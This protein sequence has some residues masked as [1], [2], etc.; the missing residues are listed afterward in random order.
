MIESITILGIQVKNDLVFAFQRLT[1]QERNIYRNKQH[2]VLQGFKVQNYIGVN[3]ME[4][5]IAKLNSITEIKH[6]VC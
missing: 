6:I 4:H 3:T 5:R 2:D 1:V